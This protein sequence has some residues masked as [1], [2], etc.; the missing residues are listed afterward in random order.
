MMGRR[1]FVAPQ[2]GATMIEVL[3]TIVIITF[4][5]LGMAG[6]QAR[7]QLSEMESYQRSQALLLLGDMANRL[8]T[9]RL[10]A[11]A[12]ASNTT[13]GGDDDCPNTSGSI[14]QR[15]LREWCNA[16]KGAAVRDGATNQGAMIGARGCI[17]QV[18]NDYLITVAWQGLTPL[19][20]PP[21]S[22]TC[23]ADQY[24]G[25]AGAKCVDDLCRRALTTIV[26][27]GVL[28]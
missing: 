23:G 15:D 9:N 8:S 17:Q 18:G 14:V 12:Y 16:L 28:S 13:Y 22:V 27:I 26:R 21:A 4:G 24:D 3:V 2:R 7:M 6:L 25:G 20:A 19:V 5:L 10:N 11:A 1:H